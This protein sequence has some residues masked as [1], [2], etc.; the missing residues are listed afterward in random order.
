M[1]PTGAGRGSPNAEGRQPT[2]KGGRRGTGTARKHTEAEIKK[3]QIQQLS[4][5][6]KVNR[7]KRETGSCGHRQREQMSVSRT[8]QHR[9]LGVTDSRGTG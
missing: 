8:P 5:G 7:G 6:Q 4:D 2:R 3:T 1:R 9:P